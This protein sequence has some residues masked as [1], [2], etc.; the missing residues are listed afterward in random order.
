MRAVTALAA[1]YEDGPMLVREIAALTGVPANYLSKIL[2]TLSRAGVLASERGRGG[3]FSLAANPATI[4]AH[5]IV[6]QFEDL[7][8]R[9]R[10]FLGNSICSDETA[11]PAHQEWSAIWN[12]YEKFLN[13]TMLADLVKSGYSK[14]GSRKRARTSRART[15]ES[16]VS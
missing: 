10:C 3:G 8:Q 12:A 4:S 15:R 9:R 11:C 5:D 13:T 6:S 2:H 14:P 16:E 1:S 7:Q